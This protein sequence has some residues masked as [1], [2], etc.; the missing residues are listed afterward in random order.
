M[1]K[2]YELIRKYV[3]DNSVITVILPDAQLLENYEMFSRI[4]I[5][6]PLDSQCE[7]YGLLNKSNVK[8]YCDGIIKHLDVLKQH[9][10]YIP[11]N[12]LQNGKAYYEGFELSQ[13]VNQYSRRSDIIIFQLPKKYNV[14]NFI[15][16]TKDHSFDIY[17]ERGVPFF[18]II[19][20]KLI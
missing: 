4:N 2:L 8:I 17:S 10:L 15:K 5:I 13:L 20:K 12:T 14:N 6:C 1:E 11:I 9:V 18:W 16:N 7:E 3:D 19:V